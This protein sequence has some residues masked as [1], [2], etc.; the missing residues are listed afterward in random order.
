MA[1]RVDCLKAKHTANHNVH[2]KARSEQQLQYLR[3]K[4]VIEFL[5]SGHN[6]MKYANE[7]T[8]G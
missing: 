7:K 3:D 6:Q 1:M 5:G 4:G 2:V 8:L